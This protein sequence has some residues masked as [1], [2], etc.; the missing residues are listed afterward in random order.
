MDLIVVGLNHRTAPLEVRERIAFDENEVVAALSRTLKE[1]V[2]SEAILLSTCNRTEFYGLS[3]DNG[4][5]EMYIRG[6]IAKAKSVDL[7]AHPGYAYTLTRLESVR[8]LLRV[9]AGLDSMVLGESQILG[10]VRRAHELSLESGAC[11]LTMNRLLQSAV[12]VGRRV[13]NETGLGAGAVSVASAAAE[14]AGKIFEDLSV[15]SVLLIGV[16]EMG[17]LT[18][19]H[20]VERGVKKLTIANR[21]FSKAE[22]LARELSGTAV[23]LDRVETALASVDIAI[24]STGSTVPIVS[25][26][27]M[28]SIVSRRGGKP[29]FIIDIA[30]PRDF[31]ASIGELDGVFLHD[32]DDMNLL[33]DRNLVKRRAEIPKAETIVEH[34]VE[35]FVAWRSSLAATPVIKR[36]RERVEE[37]RSQ[38]VERHRKRFCGADREQVDLLT[39]S[40]VNKILHP[41]M[42]RVRQW[43]DEGDLGALRIDTLYEAFEL[44]RPGDPAREEE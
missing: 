22:E 9:A 1:R 17:T 8:H 39:E 26:S 29:I 12:L 6:L 38:E 44:D 31:E 3:T 36:L 35:A 2:L 28:Q 5:A 24:S 40:L 20:M 34:E 18:A 14:L 21:T 30:V 27:L 25:R 23:P 43:S 37:L 11:G 32:I 41:I 15:R 33:V 4:A 10:Q 42:S 19:R 13:R 7:T 16:G